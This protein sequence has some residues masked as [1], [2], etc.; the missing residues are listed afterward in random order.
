MKDTPWFNGPGFGFGYGTGYPFFFYDD[1]AHGNARI[2][3]SEQPIICYELGH[4]GSNPVEADQREREREIATP[5]DIHE[6]LDRAVRYHLVLNIFY[7]PVY[8]VEF[9]LCR[10]AIAEIKRYIAYKGARV[11]HLAN[12]AVADWWRARSQAQVAVTA[13]SERAFQWQTRCDWP[14]GMV[15][16]RLL[17]GRKIG[18]V[19]VDGQSAAYTCKREFGGDWLY[20]VI[21]AGQHRV[22]IGLA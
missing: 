15:V 11:L 18:S 19:T 8:I 12:N 22:N 2:P 5:E 4:R 13:A 3:V 14:A 6:A 20:V 16:R 7:H 9:P 17:K 10:A 21:P 1:A